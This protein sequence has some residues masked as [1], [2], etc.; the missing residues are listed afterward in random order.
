MRGA[1]GPAE[2][3]ALTLNARAELPP[4]ELER[5]AAEEMRRACDAGCGAA[6][7]CE[8]KELRCLSPGRPNPTYRFTFV[9]PPG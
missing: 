6:A 4:E 1:L 3:I 2:R 8:T 9:A 5:I 7:A